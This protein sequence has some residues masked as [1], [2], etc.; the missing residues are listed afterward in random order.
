MRFDAIVVA[1]TPHHLKPKYLSNVRSIAH[2]FF[3][4]LHFDVVVVVITKSNHVLFYF[5]FASSSV[6]LLEFFL[7]AVM[8][9]VGVCV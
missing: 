1:S 9:W 3:L 7:C 2:N 5:L 4:S 8:R 6:F